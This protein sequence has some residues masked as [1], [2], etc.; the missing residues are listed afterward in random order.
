MWFFIGGAQGGNPGTA[1]NIDV[2]YVE[3]EQD[4]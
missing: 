4:A 3:I 1:W 2:N